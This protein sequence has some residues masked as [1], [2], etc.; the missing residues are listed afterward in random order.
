MRW[1]FHPEPLEEYREATLYYAERG[2]GVASGLS[3]SLRALMHIEFNLH[4]DTATCPMGRHTRPTVDVQIAPN[5]ESLSF[6]QHKRGFSWHERDYHVKTLRSIR[7]Q[8]FHRP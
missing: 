4:V 5:A 6:F 1:E 8:T 2:P 3:K 7:A